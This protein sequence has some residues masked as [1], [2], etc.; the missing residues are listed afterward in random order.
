MKT[1]FK[2]LAIAVVLVTIERALPTKFVVMWLAFDLQ[3][4]VTLFKL[5]Y[6]NLI[7]SK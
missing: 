7:V 5:L 2:C 3:L 1:L 6:P 4:R